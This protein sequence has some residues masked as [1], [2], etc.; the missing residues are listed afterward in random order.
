MVAQQ[1]RS[2]TPGSRDSPSVPCY[3]WRLVAGA[4]SS[5]RK[6]CE[7]GPM[8]PIKTDH[9][10]MRNQTHMG[11]PNTGVFVD[12]R[13]II[14]LILTSISWIWDTTNAVPYRPVSLWFLRPLLVRW[15]CGFRCQATDGCSRS[16]VIVWAITGRSCCSVCMIQAQIFGLF[17]RS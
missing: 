1:A 16:T 14:S 3:D 12:N 15:T 11:H 8:G 7:R 17:G 2:E 9:Q 6:V 4:P 10:L 5:R 13:N